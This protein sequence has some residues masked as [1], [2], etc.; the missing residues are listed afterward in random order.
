MRHATSEMTMRVYGDPRLLD[1]SHAL[2]ALPA[3]P[4]GAPEFGATGIGH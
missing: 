3:L 1:V 4:L 2:D